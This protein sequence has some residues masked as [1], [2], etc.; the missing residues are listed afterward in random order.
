MLDAVGE[1]VE[2]IFLQENLIVL[3][4]SDA[5]PTFRGD[6]GQVS[7][8]DITAA[9]PNIVSKVVFWRVMENLEV[10]SDHIPVVTRLSLGPRR[11]AVRKV[12]NWGATDWEAFN[13]QLLVRLGGGPSGPVSTPEGIDNSV[14]HVMA[15]LQQTMETCVPVKR[16]CSYS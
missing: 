2:N 1:L 10:G 4:N 14:D 13:G 7:W 6:R 16:I 11:A 5:P 15:A 9:S 8:I 12:L 3:N